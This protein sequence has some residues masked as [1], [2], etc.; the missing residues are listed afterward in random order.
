MPMPVSDSPDAV[1]DNRLGDAAVATCP[2]RLV[3]QRCPDD[4]R[5]PFLALRS[6]LRLL[7]GA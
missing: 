6:L 2:V 3:H 5:C 7:Q 1:A 4:C